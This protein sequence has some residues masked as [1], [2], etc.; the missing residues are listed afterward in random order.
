MCVRSGTAL[1]FEK[2]GDCMCTTGPGSYGYFSIWAMKN[3]NKWNISKTIPYLPMRL[4][5]KPEVKVGS[6]ICCD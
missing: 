2:D 4:S 1:K 5:L 6:L 3:N